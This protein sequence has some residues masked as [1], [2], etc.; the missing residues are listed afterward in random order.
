L[1]FIN[2]LINENQS[3]N[4]NEEKRPIMV[5]TRDIRQSEAHVTDVRRI[6]EE[7]K[8]ESGNANDMDIQF[9]LIIFSVA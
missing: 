9:N 6:K 3:I 4:E 1:R 8:Y 7:K 2:L 5:N